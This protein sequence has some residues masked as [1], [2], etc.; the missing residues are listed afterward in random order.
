LFA[1]LLISRRPPNEPEQ[2]SP[3]IVMQNKTATPIPSSTATPANGGTSQPYSYTLQEGEDV[4]SV[5][6]R[7]G[8]KDTD[9]AQVLAL[10][11]L[12]SEE[13]T[14]L[15][16]GTVILLPRIPGYPDFSG[17]ETGEAFIMSPANPGGA[18]GLTPIYGMATTEDFAFY[19]LE[20]SGP[21]TNSNFAIIVDSNQAVPQTDII[22]ELDSNKY[23]P[24][25]YKLRLSVYDTTN[26]LQA[27][28]TVILYINTATPTSDGIQVIPSIVPNAAQAISCTGTVYLLEPVNLL[29]QPN[30][31]GIVIGHIPGETGVEVLI[32]QVQSDPSTNQEWY[33]VQVQNAELV[34]LGWM[35]S[36]MVAQTSPCQNTSNPCNITGVVSL[37]TFTPTWTPTPAPGLQ[38]DPIDVM[39]TPVPGAG[40]QSDPLA[41]PVPAQTML[42]PTIVPP[43]ALPSSPT[44]P[45]Y[46]PPNATPIAVFDL[47]LRDGGYVLLTTEQVGDI[48][49]NALVRINTA[50]YNGSEWLYEVIAKD[51]QTRG[52]AHDWQLQYAPDFVPGA[53]TPTAM[54]DGALGS[55]FYAAVTNQAVGNIPAGTQVQISSAFY[56]GIEWNYNI[57]DA[58]GRENTARESQLDFAPGYTSGMATP[59]AAYFDLRGQ[60]LITLVQVGNIP[61]NTPVQATSGYYDGNEW[62]YGI[63]TL[64]STAFADARASQLRAVS[65]GEAGV[66]PS[67]VPAT[68]PPTLL[69]TLTVTPIS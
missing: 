60:V 44:P 55:G 61:A 45:P 7:F 19:R 46:I 8:Y 15:A 57:S 54:F 9:M 64:D 59:T 27:S 58:S 29:S 40:F 30:I 3:G 11:G 66:Q 16:A 10:N 51:G 4:F 5:I 50:Q 21:Q 17:C 33:F 63:V 14:R 47:A 69:P 24:G 32:Q 38:G 22:G 62:V 23:H 36:S 56:N 49:A 25:E 34:A 12:T 13:S 67:P 41:T 52:Q 35:P 39:A 53:V 68:V 18:S 37:P 20:I 26:T 65:L 28:C 2:G 31:N 48:P 42:M 1:A 6:L 43:C